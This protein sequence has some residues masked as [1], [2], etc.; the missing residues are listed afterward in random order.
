VG[1]EIGH[2]V[3]REIR[4]HPEVVRASRSGGHLRDRAAAFPRRLYATASPESSAQPDDECRLLPWTNLR[5]RWAS[6]TPACGC[7]VSR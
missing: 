2:R 5:S 7:S 6:R 3:R 4:V 1:S